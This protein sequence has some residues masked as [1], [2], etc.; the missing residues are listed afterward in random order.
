MLRTT[1]KKANSRPTAYRQFPVKVNGRRKRNGSALL[2]PSSSLEC[3]GTTFR[4]EPV[5]KPFKADM[6]RRVEKS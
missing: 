5:L 1:V 6:R 3:Q 4:A 2:T